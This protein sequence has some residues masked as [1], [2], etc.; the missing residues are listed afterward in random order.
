MKREGATTNGEG[1]LW[2]PPAVLPPQQLSVPPAIMGL[3][4]WIAWNQKYSKIAPPLVME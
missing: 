3:R 1:H 4:V 2:A